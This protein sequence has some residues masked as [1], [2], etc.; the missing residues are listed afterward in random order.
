MK[1]ERKSYTKAEVE[2]ISNYLHDYVGAV[3]I[4]EIARMCLKHGI[5]RNPYT[6]YCKV[7]SLAYYFQYLNPLK[8]VNGIKGQLDYEKIIQSN[9]TVLK[10]VG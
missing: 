2:I 4:A 5:K 7:L 3:S 10:K 1:T 6:L 9:K 8:T